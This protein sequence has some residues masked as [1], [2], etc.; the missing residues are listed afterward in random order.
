MESI[1][2]FDFQIHLYGV[3]YF[4]SFVIGYLFFYWIGKKGFF[5]KDKKFQRFLEKGLDDLALASILGVLVGGRLGYVL[6]YDLG[7]FMENPLH[8]FFLWQGGMAFVGGVIGVILGFFYIKRKYSLNF[9]HLLLLGDLVLIIGTLGIFL[10]RIGNFLNQE[11]YG[12]PVKDLPFVLNINLLEN[13]GLYYT[14]DRVDDKIR[15]NTNIIEAIL[16]GLVLFIAFLIIFFKKYVKNNFK[17]G[18]IVALFLIFYSI[19][20]FFAEFLRDE[21]MV[22]YVWIFTSS[23][24]FMFLFFFSGLWIWIYLLKDLKK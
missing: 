11:L 8:I 10:G 12:K 16:E 6:F 14:Y 24:W 2:F 22:D 20:R 18:F 1:D 13:V 15:V 23:Q 19:F 7:Y 4:V 9:S 21:S 3:F 17:P 5:K